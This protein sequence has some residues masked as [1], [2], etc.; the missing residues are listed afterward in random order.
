MQE[1]LCIETF[2][3]VRE[4][5]NKMGLLNLTQSLATLRSQLLMQL[6]RAGLL[7]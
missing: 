6:E 1:G 4:E 2:D 3:M 5:A 7:L